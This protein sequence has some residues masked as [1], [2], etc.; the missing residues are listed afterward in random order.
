V[1]AAVMSGLLAANALTG[2]P[3]REDIVGYSGT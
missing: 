1:E 2:S 3:R